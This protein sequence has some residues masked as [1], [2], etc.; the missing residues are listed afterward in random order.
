MSKGVSGVIVHAVALFIIYNGNT[1]G[2]VSSNGGR[3]IGKWK[4]ENLE[5]KNN[6]KK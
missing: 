6:G 3:K 1:D 5:R 4:H 2:Y